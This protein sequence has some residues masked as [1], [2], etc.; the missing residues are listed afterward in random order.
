L[1]Q[2]AI[3]LVLHVAVNARAPYGIHR[4]ELLYLAMGRHLKLWGMDFP[5]AIAVVAEVSRTFLGESLVALRFLP[6]VFGAAIVAL[7]GM[8]ARELGGGRFA[9]GL[10]AFCVLTSPL[11]LRAANLLQPVVID[12]LI[13]TALLYTLVRLSRGHGP[14]EW[15]LLGLFTGLGLLTKFSIAF[16]ALGILAAALLSPLRAAR[17]TW[18][19]WLGLAAALAVGAPSLPGHRPDG[20]PPRQPAGA[21]RTVRLPAGTAALGT[22]GDPGVGRTHGPVLE[23]DA[24]AVSAGGLVHH[25][26]NRAP[27]GGPG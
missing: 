2:A 19:P 20:R 15:I 14:G 18:W 23:P 9:Q 21:D 11:F 6:A 8:V 24:Q 26:H 4:D 13:W 25:R 7:A 10:A 5:P 22:G 16:I 27:D 3:K 17:S 12:Q 1:L